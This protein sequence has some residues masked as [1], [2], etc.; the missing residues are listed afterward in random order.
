MIK[1][2]LFGETV[3]DL[4]YCQEKDKGFLQGLLLGKRFYLEEENTKPVCKGNKRWFIELMVETGL[5]SEKVLF[6]AFYYWNMKEG[7]TSEIWKSR[8]KTSGQKSP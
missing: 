6:P 2:P 5:I 8:N 4:P 1:I 7:I 3:P